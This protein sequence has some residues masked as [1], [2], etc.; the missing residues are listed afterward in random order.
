V[1]LGCPRQINGDRGDDGNIGDA[2]LRST[3]MPARLLTIFLVTISKR[4]YWY[5]Q[6]WLSQLTTNNEV[7][8]RRGLI[9]R[10]GIA[11]I[12][13]IAI[14]PPKNVEAARSSQSLR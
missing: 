5:A 9:G 11:N 2:Y 3:S 10:K 12:P 1:E 13:I 4:Y 8:P 6:R 7:A 14:I